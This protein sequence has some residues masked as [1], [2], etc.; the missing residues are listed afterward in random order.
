MGIEEKEVKLVELQTAMQEA[1]VDGDI[2]KLMSL[3]DSYKEIA[4]SVQQERLSANAAAIVESKDQLI[5]GIAAL[6]S[7]SGLE[8]LIGTPIKNLA[9]FVREAQEGSKNGPLYGLEYNMTRRVQ[10][11]RRS[12]SSN[13]EP[14]TRTVRANESVSRVKADG[15]TETMTIK[16]V[17]QTYAS[18][19]MRD[20]ALY[21]DKKAWSILF[22]KVNKELEP[23]FVDEGPVAGQ[24]DVQTTE[25]QTDADETE[26]K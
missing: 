18:D 10:A 11:A 9:W 3:T 8:N 7:A 4:K 2:N 5:Q 14:G 21:K 13:G 25:D 15:S 22:P 6:V 17:V 26:A 1:A 16:E 24:P 23:P 19:S 12:A 20:S